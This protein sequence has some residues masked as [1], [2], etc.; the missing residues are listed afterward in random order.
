MCVCDV[1]RKYKE[2]KLSIHVQFGMDA[3][4]QIINQV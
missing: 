3:F 1:D 2:F 4:K